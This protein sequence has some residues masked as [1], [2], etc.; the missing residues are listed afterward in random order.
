[1]RDMVPSEFHLSQNYPDPFGG[2]TTIKFCV[3]YK[4]RVRIDLCDIKRNAIKRI[5]D[6]EKEAGTYKIEFDGSG[7][8]EG[9]YSYTLRAGE[10]M[11]TKRMNLRK[12]PAR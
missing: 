10:F 11:S 8:R 12:R 1:M 2:K 7:L 4:C 5:M 3:A 6:E 9:V